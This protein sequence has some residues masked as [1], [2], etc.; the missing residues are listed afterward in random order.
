V[1]ISDLPQKCI[2]R[3]SSIESQQS[4]CT[5]QLLNFS[6]SC[7]QNHYVSLVSNKCRKLTPL[8]DVYFV[9]PSCRRFNYHSVLA[10][11]SM[12]GVSNIQTVGHMVYQSTLYGPVTDLTAVTKV[13]HG[14]TEIFN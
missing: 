2:W 6:V 8:G 10:G 3:H 9:S 1:C 12:P 4:L 14:S 7:S 13:A 11:T 5:K